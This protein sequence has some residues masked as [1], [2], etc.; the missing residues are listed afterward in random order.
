MPF[1]M[2]NTQK[3]AY[4]KKRANDFAALTPTR[5]DPIKPG[6]RSLRLNLN[7]DALFPASIK[8]CAMTGVIRSTWARLA[9]SGTTPIPSV[10]IYL[11]TD[12]RRKDCL[13]SATTAAAVSSH[14]VSIARLSLDSFS[15]SPK[16]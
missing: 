16:H 5:R 8:A 10:D 11:A 9:T 3:R 14:D 4:S 13:P 7:H 6:P 15:T 12:N 2:V 1:K